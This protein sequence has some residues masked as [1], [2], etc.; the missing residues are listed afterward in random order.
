MSYLCMHMHMHMCMHMSHTTCHMCMHMC[1]HMSMCMS[2][3]CVVMID[4][5]NLRDQ[6]F[7][8]TGFAPSERDGLHPTKKKHGDQRKMRKMR[9]IAL[10]DQTLKS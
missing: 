4:L 1:M 9:E 2:L 7:P 5:G 10:M 6:I 8:R 3:V